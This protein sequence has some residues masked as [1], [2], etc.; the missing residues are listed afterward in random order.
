MLATFANVIAGIAW[1]PQ[2]RGFLAVGVAVVVLMGSVYLLLATNVANR[3]GF[4][5]ALTGLMGF[6]FVLGILWWVFG[7]GMQGRMASWEVREVNYD[8]LSQAVTGPASQLDTSELPDP[9]AW[10]ELTPEEVEANVAEVE[11]TL[12]GWSILPESD[13]AF[14]EASATVNEYIDEHPMSA[15]G[16]EDAADVTF[17]WAFETGGKSGLPDDPNRLDR[18]WRFVK[19]T[20]WEL[21]SPPIYALL[22]VQPVIDVEP[23]PGQPAPTPEP[24]PDQPVVSYVL[25]RDLGDRRFPPAMVTIFSGI[26]FGVLANMLHRRDRRFAEARGLAT[27]D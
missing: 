27:V 20:F 12:G 26:L 10:D 25:V 15:I 1:D 24:D 23:E 22:Q 17:L 5:L 13:P 2:I 16:V 11:P 7:I 21:R 19:N 4:L 9:G 8:E 18:I 3:L 6:M 14:G